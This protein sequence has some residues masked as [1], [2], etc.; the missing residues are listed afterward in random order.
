MNRLSGRARWIRAGIVAGIAAALAVLACGLPHHPSLSCAFHAL[1]GLP[2]LFC[3]GTRAAG[4]LLH[5]QWE[6]ALYLNPL[7]FPA[8][9]AALLVAGSLA[10]EA[11][12][13]RPLCGWERALR[14]T[15]GRLAAAA[16]ALCLAWWFPHVVLSL[17]TP[18]P[19]LV[20]LHNP[21]AGKLRALFDR[22]GQE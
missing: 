4:A 9:L 14:P 21:V 12:R 8:L 7:A 1:T 2:C 19:E 17:K 5:G 22:H 15:G 11:A 13:G 20:N 3:G 18:K 6:R 10:I 16:A